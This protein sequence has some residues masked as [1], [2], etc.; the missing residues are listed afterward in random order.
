LLGTSDTE[1]NRL[2]LS[3]LLAAGF[4]ITDRRN[5]ADGLEVARTLEPDVIVMDVVQGNLLSLELGRKLQSDPVTQRI[6][7][8]AV[9]GEPDV[10][11]VMVTLRVRPCSAA[12]LHAE[13][14]RVLP[15]QTKVM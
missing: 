6:P 11:Q 3:R 12:S 14:N 8:I 9:T 1:P 7:L 2:P 15:P 10:S 4:Q 13:V 5:D